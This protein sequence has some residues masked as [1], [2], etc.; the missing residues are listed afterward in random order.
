MSNYDKSWTK[1]KI[2]LENLNNFFLWTK[3]DLLGVNTN[4][5]LKLDSTADSLLH[6]HCT[7]KTLQK[8]LTL[9]LWELKFFLKMNPNKS[10]FTVLFYNSKK[11][12]IEIYFKNRNTVFLESLFHIM[13]DTLLHTQFCQ[14][15]QFFRKIVH[16]NFPNG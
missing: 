11:L 15:T 1:Y 7:R 13:H 14:R 2:L 16:C 9:K 6:A 5:L 12:R 4:T 3:Y 10:A 8:H